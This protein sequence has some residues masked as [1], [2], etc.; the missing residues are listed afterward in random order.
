MK[1]IAIF[2]NKGGVGKTTLL[3]NLASF[4]STNKGYKV[5]VVDADPQCNTSTYMLNEADF[6]NIYYKREAFTIDDIAVP[7]TKGQGYIQQIKPIRS[8]TFGV[9]LIPGNPRF[10]IAEDFL[11]KDW[12]DVLSSQIRGIRTNMMFFHL[13]TLCSEYDYAFFDMGPSLGAINRAVLLA[14]DYFITPMS[15]DIFSL[16]ALENIGISI[17]TWKKYFNQSVENINLTDK[18]D[19]V[20]QKTICDI[21]FLGFVEQQYITKSVEGQRQ[22]V[23]SYERILAQIPAEIEKHIIGPINENRYNVDYNIGSIPNLYSIVP[24]SQTAHKPIFLLNSS[25]GVLGAHYKKV[26]DY[27][28]LIDSISSHVL[29]NMEVMTHD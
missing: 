18:A 7:L 11:S 27:A 16:L 25:D 22:A 23:N 17:N 15:S 28:S 14:C 21:K 1:A 5:I 6:F 10:S 19:L 4:L 13:L 3:C 9:D 12:V 2:N 29:T 26:A 24:M 20:G 8:D